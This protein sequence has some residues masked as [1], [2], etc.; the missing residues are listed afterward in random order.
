MIEAFMDARNQ[1]TENQLRMAQTQQAMGTGARNTM[2]AKLMQEAY[3]TD[4][5]N[6]GNIPTQ[7]GIPP[8]NVENYPESNQQQISPK[9]NVSQVSGIGGVGNSSSRGQRAKRILQA[10]KI[11]DQTP[12]EK[13]AMEIETAYQK[14]LGTHA[15]KKINELQDTALAGEQAEDTYENAAE[16]MR[17]PAFK[18][19]RDFPVAPNLQYSWYKRFGT[20]DQINL[21]GKFSGYTNQ[22]ILDSIKLFP[23]RFTNKDMSFMKHMKVDDQND[24]I[25]M[26]QGKLE[27]AWKYRKLITETS[28]LASKIALAKRIPVD[29]AYS[30]ARKQLNV[31]GMKKQ[32]MSSIYGGSKRRF[33]NSETGQIIDE[34]EARTQG[35]I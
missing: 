7:N 15:A 22:F 23:Q 10:L 33:K 34:A 19:M 21:L 18:N 32:I 28:K 16:V 27:S 31:D 9:R 5:Q 30:Q 8:S 17:N 13:Q 20:P 1:G 3:G 4:E 24:T 29:E 12:E 2:I 6:S 25:S 11:V 35:I 26:M 14:E